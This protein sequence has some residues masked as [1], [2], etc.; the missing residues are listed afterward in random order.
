M[1]DQHPITWVTAAPLWSTLLGSGRADPTDQERAA[2]AQPSLLRFES[3]QFMD[4]L[5]RLL[6]TAPERL[7][8]HKA[9]PHSYRVRPPGVDD[10]EN[11]EPDPSAVKLKLYQPFHGHFNLVAASLVCQIPGLPDRAVAPAHGEKV[12][13]V[14]RRLNDGGELAWIEDASAKTGKAWAAVDQSTPA[15]LADTED[16]LPLFPLGYQAAGRNRRIFVG[17]IPTSSRESYRNAGPAAPPVP[18]GGPDPRAMTLQTKVLDPLLSVQQLSTA[19]S[20]SASQ[21]NDEAERTSPFIALELAQ[22]LIENDDP[23]K[24]IIDSGQDA[25]PGSRQWQ[26][27]AWLRSQSADPTHGY[28][29]LAAIRAAWSARAAICGEQAGASGPTLNLLGAQGYSA[30]LSDQQLLANTL[31]TLPSP[32][33]QP[34]GTPSAPDPAAQPLPK[35]DPRSDARYVLRCVYQR[36]QCRPPHED[37]LSPASDDFSIAP[38]FDF[39]APHRRITISMP[40]DTSPAGLRKFPKNVSFLLSDQLKQQMGRLKD[41]KS[42]TSG[43][44]DN[45]GI[46]IGLVCSFSIPIITICA[47]F[48]LIIFIYLLNIVFWWLPFFRICLPLGL[49]GKS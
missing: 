48:V 10:P 29:W 23:W 36:P 42:M 4:D 43:D 35:L 37:V 28:T 39:D 12:G 2:M 26:L 13:F 47:L 19:P 6:A 45:P 24:A 9:T 14:I 3:D 22:F 33:P 40:I 32:R 21:K 18:T 1:S 25:V 41:M 5:N 7:G 16:V 44:F 30:D 11:W 27:F 8:D 49:K 34:A 46:D 31:T 17:L 38:H 15:K 20:T